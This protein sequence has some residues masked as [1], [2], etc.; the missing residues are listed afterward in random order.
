MRV[1]SVG[2]V[3]AHTKVDPKLVDGARQFEAMMLEQMLKGLSFSGAPGEDPEDSQA[4][5]A[6]TVQSFGTEAVAKAIAAGGGFGL[7]RQIVRQV[8][9]EQQSTNGGQAEIPGGTKVR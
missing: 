6:G 2:A 3:P 7:A 8:Q 1:D 4:G 9:A 5:A